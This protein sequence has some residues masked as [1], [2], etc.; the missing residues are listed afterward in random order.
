MGTLAYCEDP[1]EMQ[2]QAAC[3]QGMYCLLG[4]KQLQGQKAS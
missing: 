3:N 2:H 4:L 1:D